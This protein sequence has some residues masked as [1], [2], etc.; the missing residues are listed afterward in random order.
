MYQVHYGS[1][2]TN[3]VTSNHVQITVAIKSQATTSQATTGAVSLSAKHVQG[4]ASSSLLHI[5]ARFLRIFFAPLLLD[6]D[7]LSLS[8]SLS[9]STA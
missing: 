3:H 4:L 5:L 9:M 1:L 2:S 7:E 8:L 6:D